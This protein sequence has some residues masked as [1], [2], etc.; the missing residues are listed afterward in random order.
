M[1]LRPTCIF[2][3]I[4]SAR[5]TILTPTNLQTFVNACDVLKISGKPVRDW[6]KRHQT[7]PSRLRASAQLS[8][9]CYGLLSQRSPH[10]DIQR[11]RSNPDGRRARVRHQSDRLLIAHLGDRNCNDCRWQFAR[12][13][14]LC[15]SCMIRCRASTRKCTSEISYNFRGW[16]NNF[17]G[18]AGGRHIVFHSFRSVCCGNWVQ[19]VPNGTRIHS[20]PSPFRDA[21][22]WHA[23]EAL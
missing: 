12:D 21:P 20:R 14:P 17:V 23:L 8:P 22:Q 4:P 18:S 16:A 15:L 9:V 3:T 2:P 11:S 19:L 6:S 1:P 7:D 13:F 5:S 10:R